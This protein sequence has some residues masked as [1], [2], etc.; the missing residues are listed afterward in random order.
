MGYAIP[1]EE[2][3]ENAVE[4]AGETNVERRRLMGAMLLPAAGY[5]N[6]AYGRVTL[7][8][9][10]GI[11]DYWT[12]TVSNDIPKYFDFDTPKVNRV[13]DS[14]GTY[15]NRDFA[16]PVR[17]VKKAVTAGTSTSTDSG[18][19]TSGTIGGGGSTGGNSSMSGDGSTGGTS[20]TT[21]GGGSTGGSSSA[22]CTHT[23]GQSYVVNSVRCDG[24]KQ[25]R[26]QNGAWTQIYQCQASE[27]CTEIQ[28]SNQHGNWTSCDTN[29]LY[30]IGNEAELAGSV[31]SRF[32]KTWNSSA[33]NYG[34]WE[35]YECFSGYVRDTAGQN[36]I[37]TSSSNLQPII[38]SFTA[39]KTSAL[40]DEN[41]T[42]TWNAS[43]A[44]NCSIA[45][46]GV[47][48]SVPALSNLALVGSWQG[49]SQFP[50]GNSISYTLMCTNSYGSKTASVT[51]TKIPL[52]RTPSVHLTASK[53]SVNPGDT[54]TLNWSATNMDK[55][56]DLTPDQI[57]S[58]YGCYFETD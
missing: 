22:S 34:A 15:A 44:T 25:I 49:M 28:N 1:T 54:V 50:N 17:C 8:V 57:A 32:K 35:F 4:A 39:S 14:N 6:Y 16:M 42:L 58:F 12:S 37:P 3:W 5:R 30:S 7:D 23:D 53:T 46:D 2:D 41:I 24:N 36:C 52:P 43:N 27:H 9:S 11:G 55:D 33:K 21:G 38:A 40:A 47:F 10:R 13:A 26:C 45:R 29:T 31:G 20:G 48:N 51:V 56:S 18:T 19:S